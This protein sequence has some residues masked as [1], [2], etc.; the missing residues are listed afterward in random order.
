MSPAPDVSVVVSTFNRAPLL[1]PLLDGLRGQT[2]GRDRFEVVVVDD[3]S[4]D[5]T[6]A[7]L[8]REL[9]RGE[10][11]LR[12]IRR[13]RNAGL[14][15][16][17][18]EGW[19]AARAEVLAF[20]DDDCEPAPDWLERGLAA[21]RANPDA[22]VQGRVLPRRSDLEGMSPWR[23]PFTRTL[24]IPA[25][26]PPVQ[27]ANVFYRREVL[28][29]IGGLDIAEFEHYPGEDADLALRAIDAG[30]EV[31]F[32]PGVLVQHAYL[33][34]GPVRKLR[35]AARWDFKV[36]AVHPG[37]RHAY[38]TRR[39][40]WKGSHYFLVRAL[41]AAVLPRRW[42]PVKAWLAVPYAVHLVERG[43]VEG[44]GPLAAPYYVAHDLIELAVSIKSTIRYRTPML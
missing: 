31:V 28:E 13:D 29:R 10:L 30:A 11:D 20:T 24:D 36:Y 41:L 18:E 43:R 5:D 25:P 19:R 44:G 40:F 39:W 33:Y 17:R 26:D 34:L 6:A 9:A 2:L 12:V 38:F 32:E 7:V 22:L 42:R 16:G 4:T 35:Y 1:G 37:L 3:G 27:T 15:V 21:V 14:T 23:R 8:E